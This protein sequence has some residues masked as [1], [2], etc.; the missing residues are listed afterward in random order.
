MKLLITTILF[1]SMLFSDTITTRYDVHVGLFGQVGHADI[2]IEQHK[3]HYKM[4]LVA[5]LSGTAAALTGNR[6]ETY[7]SEGEIKNGLYQPLRFSKIKKTDHE[8]RVQIYNF[9]HE[10]QE[11]SLVEEKNKWVTQSK[12]DPIALRLLKKEVLQHSKKEKILDEYQAQDVLSSYMNALTYS[13]QTNKSYE[14]RAI[15]AHNDDNDITLSFL[16]DIQV[17]EISQSFSDDVGHIYNLNVQ[18]LDTSEKTV[19]VY[20]ALDNDGL[21]KEAVLADSFWIG[22]IR[23]TRTYHEVSRN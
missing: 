20:I 16:D 19:D 5:T 21:L 13:H 1:V 8:E 14:L 11:I 6:V 18:P 3:N 23:A 4:E 15:G 12:F 17:K 10:K 9:N 2:S 22:K 7:I